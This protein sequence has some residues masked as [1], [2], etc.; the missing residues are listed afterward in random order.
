MAENTRQRKKTGFR[1]PTR[2]INPNPLGAASSISLKQHES[3]VIDPSLFGD[4]SGA[5]G[6]YS[7]GL[8]YSGRRKFL[9]D[10]E[11]KLKPPSLFMTCRQKRI[12]MK[13]QKESYKPISKLEF[14]KK[15]P[16]S[17]TEELFKNYISEHKKAP[18]VKKK[19]AFITVERYPSVNPAEWDE[20]KQAGVT[21]YVHRSTG[22]HS[23]QKP[24]EVIMSQNCSRSGELGSFSDSFCDSFCGDNDS[25]STL[26][27]ED[28]ISPK[29][30][31]CWGCGSLAY[32]GTEVNELLDYLGDV[33][34]SDEKTP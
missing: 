13:L 29:V 25:L 32:D 9:K 1:R 30:E 11:E 20:V 26:D 23:P 5:H 12:E 21:Y 16:P 4:A 31:D 22:E 6:D 27:E 15:A 28:E 2:R 3:M 19:E 10:D 18:P 24:W 33:P 7:M 8:F 14:T 34:W 17:E